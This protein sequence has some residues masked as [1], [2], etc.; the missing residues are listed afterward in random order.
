MHAG[1]VPALIFERLGTQLAY[2][3]RFPSR[4]L[5]FPEQATDVVDPGLDHFVLTQVPVA[6]F[7]DQSSCLFLCLVADEHVRLIQLRY[8]VDRVIHR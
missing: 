3:V 7:S 4:V 1:S 2:Y 6:Q 5:I 8:H